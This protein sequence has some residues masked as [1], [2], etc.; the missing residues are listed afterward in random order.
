M[1]IGANF[2][3]TSDAQIANIE[4]VTLT[5]AATLNLANQTEAFTI[6]GSSGNDVI[7]GGSGADTINAGSGNDT[8]LVG[9]ND[10][11]IDGGAN[12]DNNLLTVGNR[13]DVM[14][15]SGNFDFTT[16]AHGNI[17]QNIETLSM[18]NAD[19]STGNSTITLNI[20]DVLDMADTGVANPTGSNGGQ[21]YDNA[22][23]IRIDGDN[24]DTVELH[25]GSG[26]WQAAT[27]ATGI[28]AGYNA[29]SHVTS[30]S[31]PAVNED[32]YVFIQT[33]VTVHV[34]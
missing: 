26:T 13:G 15:L 7:T 11:S 16:A 3:S 2:T 31:N 19:G 10:A 29:F 14:V 17:F 24:A 27:G 1:Q 20:T 28:P 22:K 4:N 32:A 8:I 6:T 25:N 12:T 30:G 21:N 34:T 18:L 5:A 33:G 23:A 9:T